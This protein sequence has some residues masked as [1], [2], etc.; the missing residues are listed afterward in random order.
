MPGRT[1]ACAVCKVDT[2][3]WQ[4]QIRRLREKLEYAEVQ[5]LK[6]VSENNRLR[7]ELQEAEFRG[8]SRLVKMSRSNQS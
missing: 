6:L 2:G 1:G 8:R 7:Q 4:K 3:P 5:N